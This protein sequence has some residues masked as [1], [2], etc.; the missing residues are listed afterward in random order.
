MSQ[1]V[2]PHF[3]VDTLTG[4][5]E[6]SDFYWGGTAE[7]YE[8][9]RAGSSIWKR[10]DEIVEALLRGV[11]SNGSKPTVLDVPVGTGR[12]VAAVESL[13]YT[14]LGMDVS[15]DML[16]QAKERS[17]DGVRFAIAN[18]TALPVRT[19]AVDAVLCI[20][21]AHLVD[22]ATLKATLVELGRVLDDGG[23][24]TLGVRVH[25]IP[26]DGERKGRLRR[27]ARRARRSFDFRFGR[28]QSHSHSEKRL[29]K[30]LAS[31]DLSVAERW[32]VTRYGDGSR[33]Y[34]FKLRPG[35]VSR[36]V[37]T[38]ELFGLPGVGKST[39]ARALVRSGRS[40]LVDGF[41]AVKDRGVWECFR[42][43]PLATSR[44]LIRLLPAAAELRN[45][46]ARKVAVSALRQRL[47]DVESRDT[48]V[49][50]EGAA[51]ELWRQLINGA[52]IN[53][54]FIRRL[55][56]V[57]D[58]TILLEAPPQTLVE[59]LSSKRSPG[60]ISRALIE[61]P[62]DGEAWVRAVTIYER[63]KEILQT[64][65]GS[66]CVLDNSGSSDEVTRAL[67]AIVSGE[68]E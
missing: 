40:D 31:A 39:T 59:R 56:P 58:G 45:P 4:M 23:F 13:G 1:R 5:S 12:F 10:E 47:V 25:S 16:A 63:I 53:D 34:I 67:D 49:H 8:A 61:E 6:R 51:H 17:G 20:R 41:S 15:Q 9:E 55:L 36:Q 33:Y 14:A 21:F 52:V 24:V 30:A 2:L 38:F 48:V 27:I 7:S 26:R 57:S 60:P 65:S 42:A 66:V 43:H 44:M 28:A 46:A 54:R 3:R 32:E 50:E 22:R 18:A 29:H 62:P 64:G 35:S 19:S 37:R 68:P 11:S